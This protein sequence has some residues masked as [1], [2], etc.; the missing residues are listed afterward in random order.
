MKRIAGGYQGTAGLIHFGERFYNPDIGRWTQPDPLDQ[1]GDLREGNPYVYAGAD[2]INAVDTTGTHSWWFW[3]GASR[4][5]KKA[6]RT[7]HRGVAVGCAAV[8]IK[9][10]YTWWK[11][12]KAGVKTTKF[13]VAGGA[14]TAGCTVNA[15]MIIGAGFET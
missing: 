10:T 2:P 6:T 12:L 5:R 3:E 4:A 11:N 13:S 1:T 9:R 14:V 15:T 7:F 8:G